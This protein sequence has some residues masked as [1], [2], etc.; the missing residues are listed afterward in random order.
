MAGGG[1]GTGRLPWK[2]GEELRMNEKTM[3]QWSAM[4]DTVTSD[5]RPGDTRLHT[6]ILLCVC[7]IHN[8]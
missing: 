4:Y 7:N 5:I 6:I 2:I 3:E 1:G 8:I